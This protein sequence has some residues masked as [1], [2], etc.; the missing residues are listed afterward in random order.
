MKRKSL[1]YNIHLSINRIDELMLYVLMLENIE[2]LLDSFA[3]KYKGQCEVYCDIGCYIFNEPDY[4]V[5]RMV[6]LFHIIVFGSKT[7]FIEKKIDALLNKELSL[8][9][10]KCHILDGDPFEKSNE[11]LLYNISYKRKRF[12]INQEKI[13]RIA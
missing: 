10:T 3:H 2:R 4:I 6:P 9:Y 8:K 7:K 1:A 12:A 13:T 5:K 11:E